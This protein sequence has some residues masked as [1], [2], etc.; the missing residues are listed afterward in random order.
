[1]ATSQINT[2]RTNIVSQWE[3]QLVTDGI[4]GVDVRR[5]YP[6]DELTAQ[7]VAWVE[8]VSADQTQLTYGRRGESLTVDGVI[9][10]NRGG[11]GE[12]T[13]D[14]AEDRALAILASLETILTADVTVS[15]TGIF[16]QLTRVESRL[17]G[18]PSG[19]RC[20]LE[21]TVE[22]EVNL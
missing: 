22:V 9:T 8:T 16:G 20:V 2:A 11:A 18:S 7:D 10:V 5:F 13:A 4:T 21:W 14:T 17:E 3:A 6:S 1:M 15:S 19:V 12:T